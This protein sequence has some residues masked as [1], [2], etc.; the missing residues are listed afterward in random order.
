MITKDGL[1][2]YIW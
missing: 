1:I 2:V